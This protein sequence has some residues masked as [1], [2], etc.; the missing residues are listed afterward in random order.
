MI[1]SVGAIDGTAI[2]A[3]MTPTTPRPEIT[4]SSAVVIG[5]TIASTVPE[6]QHEH[7]HRGADTDDLAQPRTRIGEL[8]AQV[9]AGRDLDP[10]VGRRLGVVEDVV[11]F[12]VGDVTRTD[13]EEERD[14]P[15]RVVLRELAR[16]PRRRAG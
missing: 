11:G 8:R 10:G 16:R 7:D 9:A 6:H 2:A 12:F 13:R 5:I 3:P 4:P 15:D 14:D 1:A